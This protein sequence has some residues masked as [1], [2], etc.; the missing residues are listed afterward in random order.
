[1]RF[2]MN[3]KNIFALMFI[4]SSLFAQKDSSL[5]PLKTETSEEED[6]TLDFSFGLNEPN[7]VAYVPRASSNNL[8]NDIIKNWQEISKALKPIFMT[9]ILPL[10]LQISYLSNLL[11]T[12][13]KFQTLVKTNAE[14]IVKFAIPLIGE[15]A[16]EVAKVAG[17]KE[18]ETSKKD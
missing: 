16:N 2:K 7:K 3:K 9:N 8:Y 1:M 5:V 18:A 12:D 14:K 6:I 4:S 13:E 17:Y 10:G 11:K 15:V